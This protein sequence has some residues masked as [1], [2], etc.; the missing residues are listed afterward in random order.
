[1]AAVCRPPSPSSRRGKRPTS[2]AGSAPIAFSASSARAAWGWCLRREEVNLRRLVALKVMLPRHAENPTAKARFLREA[3]AQAAVEHDHVIAIYRADE[4]RGVPYLAMPLLQGQTLSAAI[5]A[6]AKVPVQEILRIG[7]EMAEGL[8]AA[9][10]KGLIHRDVKPANVWLEGDRRR[11]KL[12]DFGLA[13]ATTDELAD[14]DEPA[15][16]PG[17]MMGTPA[18]MSP[19]QA[20]GDAVDGRTDLF[21]LGVVLYEMAAGERPF[22]GKDVYGLLTSL[23]VDHPAAP[24]EKNPAVPAALSSL[25]LRLLAKTPDERPATAAAVAEAVRR[26]R[27]GGRRVR[28]WC[29]PRRRRTTRGRTSTRRSRGRSSTCRRPCRVPDRP[30]ERGT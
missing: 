8:A 21:S 17:T 16:K 19:E 2:S 1:M 15:T 10:D 18:Y 13:R 12:L 28:R 11:V 30:G 4:D 23:A 26:D 20:R 7:R 14:S 3:R 27:G 6:N 25:I 29:T 5:K 9:H 24:R 22:K